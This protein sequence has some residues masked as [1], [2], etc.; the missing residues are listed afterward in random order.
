MSEQHPATGVLRTFRVRTITPLTVATFVGWPDGAQPHLVVVVRGSWR[1]GADG[2]L[3]ALP[4]SYAC[5]DTFAGG[6]RDL[7]GECI[8]ASDF[9]PFKARTDVLLVGSAYTPGGKP[10]N[11]VELRVGVGEWSRAVRVIGD[12]HVLPTGGLSEPLPFV[13]MPLTWTRTAASADN[14][15]GTGREPDESGM[16]RAPNLIDPADSQGTQP[17][18]TGPV[19]PRWPSRDKR[20]GRRY[21]DAWLRQ[22]WPGFA[23]DFDPGY[24]QA[25]PGAQQL[26]AWL[27]GD[28]PVVLQ[29]LLPTTPT[30]TGQLPGWRVRCL[31]SAAD[32]SDP[33]GEPTTRELDL[34]LDTLTIN[35][36][37]TA[38]NGEATLTLAWRG[39]IAADTVWARN[40]HD[41]RVAH[42]LMTDP[43]ASV[44]ALEQRFADADANNETG[45]DLPALNAGTLAA[46]LQTTPLFTRGD[47]EPVLLPGVSD[48]VQQLWN[49]A[50]ALQTALLESAE[51]G[52]PIAW[53][54]ENSGY[55]PISHGDGDGEAGDIEGDAE[56]VF[57]RLAWTL[58]AAASRGLVGG[59]A[60]GSPAA[61]ALQRELDDFHAAG[62]FQPY[63][64]GLTPTAPLPE[65]TSP[66]TRDDV[67]AAAAEGTSLAGFDLRG[68]DLSGLS[69]DAANLT[70]CVLNGANLAGTT[71]VGANLARAT[72]AGCNLAGATLTGCNARAADFTGA[73]L[74]DCDLSHATLEQATFR[75]ADLSRADLNGA[76]A[77]FAIFNGATL[78]R[79]KASGASFDSAWMDDCNLTSAALDGASLADA[80]LSGVTATGCNARGAK[81]ANL[82]AS[83]ADFSGADWREADLTGSTWYECRATQA[84]FAAAALRGADFMAADLS[85][86]VFD[87]AD[88]REGR[89]LLATLAGASLIKC[90][91]MQAT[92]ENAVLSGA[93]FAG[94]NL[95]EAELLGATLD[96]S[97]FTSANVGGTRL[98]LS[99]GG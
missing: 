24:W 76:R 55:A 59:T 85:A 88:C 42:E 93:R 12:R 35:T 79:A 37:D 15:V 49:D 46:L 25:A 91:L 14:P 92:F 60:A 10:A 67:M 87:L 13:Q 32:A 3:D 64:P 51:A 22:R 94:S 95:Y 1:I 69:L 50:A 83:K 71:L 34:A 23:T 48:E 61:D 56:T 96:G 86:A 57:T 7:Y 39:R 21:D 54:G 90:N 98:A 41:V 70:D 36:N 31:V 74:T 18:G 84:N 9:V 99:A 73:T 5:G 43:L 26:P 66:H 47:G 89:F 30:W 4:A 20:Q 97:D 75:D 68:L 63:E 45:D 2:T 16:L 82:R 38:D 58:R 65:E 27:S 8:R 19:N 33:D 6:E 40:V 78:E 29:N 52:N 11:A 80:S 77:R 44:E 62:R 28:E 72:L 53:P 17:A 81:A